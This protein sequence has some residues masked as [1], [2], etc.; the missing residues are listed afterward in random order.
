[1]GEEGPHRGKVFRSAHLAEQAD[2]VADHV[3][4]GIPVQLLEQDGRGRLA[5]LPEQVEQPPAGVAAVVAHQVLQQ[6]LGG[7]CAQGGEDAGRLLPVGVRVQG[8]LQQLVE[9]R[10]GADPFEQVAGKG[11]QFRVVPV[12]VGGRR[13]QG[14]EPLHQFVGPVVLCAR[15]V[16]TGE[17]GE[18]LED[19]RPG[20]GVQPG[21]AQHLF[22]GGPQAGEP[23]P[24]AAGCQLLGNGGQPM[25]RVAAHRAALVLQGHGQLHEQAVRFRL[26]A[27]AEQ[28]PD[29]R[30]QGGHAVLLFQQ[31]EAALVQLVEQGGDV[32]RSS[33]SR[34]R[35]RS[36][37]S[38]SMARIFSPRAVCTSCW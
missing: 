36:R 13:G 37:C 22:Q 38:S 35:W 5:R 29:R 20:L 1:M 34:R 26:P 21:Q 4:G 33:S 16:V 9:D 28:V 31:G 32:P 2:N 30:G 17:T 10:R 8:G 14:L 6:H 7:R 3:P 19:L 27:F 24:L 23:L 12:R 11:A 25:G 18:G 15:Q